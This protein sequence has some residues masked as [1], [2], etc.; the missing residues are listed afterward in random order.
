MEDWAKKQL[1]NCYSRSVLGRQILVC[2]LHLESV[3]YGFSYLKKNRQKNKTQKNK[4]KK[5]QQK[6]TTTKTILAI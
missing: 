5:Q 3:E 4:K 6:I 2:K 1:V